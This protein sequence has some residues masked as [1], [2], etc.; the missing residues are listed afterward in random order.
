MT[1][2]LVIALVAIEY[3]GNRYA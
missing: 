3:L 1:L 2:T